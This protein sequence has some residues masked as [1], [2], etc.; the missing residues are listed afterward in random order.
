MKD[1]GEFSGD[2]GHCKP[3]RAAYRRWRY[4][5]R[6]VSLEGFC[7]NPACT[8]PARDL[9]HDHATDAVRGVLCRQCNVALGCVN[10]DVALLHGL[11]EYLTTM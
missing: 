3:C 10:D 7:Q 11:V 8:R 5:N 6:G 9:D 1:A 2:H 4:A